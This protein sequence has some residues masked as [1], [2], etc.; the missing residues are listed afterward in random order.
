MA[1]NLYLSREELSQFI[2]E[3][4]LRLHTDDANAGQID[5][6]IVAKILQDATGFID[7][8]LRQRFTLPLLASCD[9]LKNCAAGYVR[10]KIYMRRP[11]GEDLPKAVVR[12][13]DNA[14]KFLAD[15]RDNKLTITIVDSATAQASAPRASSKVAV[16]TKDRRKGDELMK[17][18]DQFGG[19]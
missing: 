15:V 8:Y 16:R 10:Y 2:D 5:E 11:D 19:V 9:E 13:F 14:K 3:N 17:Y 1:I 7:A 4:T 12:E 6:G 18:Y